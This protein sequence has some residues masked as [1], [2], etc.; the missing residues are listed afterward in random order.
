MYGVELGYGVA[1]M[2]QPV[3]QWQNHVPGNVLVDT[4]A[5]SS[6]HLVIYQVMYDSFIAS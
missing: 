5:V 4:P 2:K 6:V 1:P 3:L